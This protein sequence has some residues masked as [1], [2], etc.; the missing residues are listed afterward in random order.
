SGFDVRTNDLSETHRP[1]DMVFLRNF[2]HRARELA[3][4]GQFS[5]GSHSDDR[6]AD[7]AHEY[8]PRAARHSGSY[9]FWIS[10]GGRIDSTH[11]R[12]PRLDARAR[13]VSRA[14]L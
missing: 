2:C 4:A 6:F 12:H 1:Q 10:F 9:G 11:A 13:A 14:L 3:S 5:G 7:L 8:G